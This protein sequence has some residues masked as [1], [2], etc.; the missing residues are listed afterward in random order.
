MI[1]FTADTHFDHS[2]IIKY[3]DRPFKSVDEMNGEMIKR[4]NDKVSNKDVVYH[5]GDFCFSRGN[6]G[7]SNIKK[8]RYQLNGKIHLI[9]GNHDD[10]DN[11][12][13][14]NCFDSVKYLSQIKIDGQKIILCH[15][16]M[17]VWNASHY[18]SW[19]LYGHSHGVLPDIGGLTFDV[20]VD[21]FDFCPLSFD[22][23]KDIMATRNKIML[24]NDGHYISE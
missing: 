17:R 3:C 22:E 23:V 14:S 9:I 8:F 7:I 2:R 13:D 24:G 5:L 18:G 6:T 20:G 19:Q 10:E 11:C 15:Y 21:R 12:V 1:F 16:S 4:W